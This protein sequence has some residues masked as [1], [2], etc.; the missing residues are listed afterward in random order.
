MII[1]SMDVFNK[2]PKVVIMI[3][4]IINVEI[5][6]KFMKLVMKD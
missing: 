2:K 4:D 6:N 3:L 1:N 5:P